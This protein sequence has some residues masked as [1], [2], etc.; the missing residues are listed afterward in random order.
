MMM[1]TTTMLKVMMM[2]SSVIPETFATDG[3]E[4]GSARIASVIP[5]STD[6]HLQLDYGSHCA[7]Y[8]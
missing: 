4:D 5:K 3:A 6:Y 8:I 1:M 7:G 2:T